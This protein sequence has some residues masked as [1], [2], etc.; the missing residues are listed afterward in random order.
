[1]RSR[2]PISLAVAGVAALAA[3]SYA[4]DP[5]PWGFGSQTSSGLVTYPQAADSGATDVTWY[6]PDGTVARQATTSDSALTVT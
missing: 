2:T 3:T 4:T 6:F 5:Y 1:M